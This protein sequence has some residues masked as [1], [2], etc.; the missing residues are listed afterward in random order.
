MGTKIIFYDEE[1]KLCFDY[2]QW[3]NVGTC[4]EE[5]C[6]YI[7]LTEKVQICLIGT[8]EDLIRELY[9]YDR[10]DLTRYGKL[11]WI[12]SDGEVRTPNDN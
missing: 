5:R 1:G 10:I 2:A 3:A 11:I 6:V 12:N 8:G 9:N 7:G 4:S